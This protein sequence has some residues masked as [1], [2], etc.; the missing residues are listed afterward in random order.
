MKLHKMIVIGLV[1]VAL[2]IVGCA[3]KGSVDT[4]PLEKS[5]QTAEGATKSAADT[6]VSAIKNADYSG[7]LAE[8][9]KL[10]GDAQL[11]AEQQQAIKDVIAQVQKA[12]ADAAG[13]AAS[14]AGKAAEDLQKALPK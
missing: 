5:F 2:G 4:G 7:A 14:E 13:G 10:A 3:K 12:I 11:T 6:A 1:A 9:Q 8:L